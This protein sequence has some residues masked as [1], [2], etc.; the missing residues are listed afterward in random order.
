VTEVNEGDLVRG[1]LRITVPADR[2]FVA[3]E[4]LLPGGLEVVDL[5]LRT[6]SLGPFQSEASREA[7]RL[8][9]RANPAASSLPWMYGT[10]AGG[11]WSPWEHK[12]V[13][14]DRVVYFARVLWKG[15]YTASYV[16]RATTAG[17][18]VRPPAHA[19]EMYNQSLGGRSEGGTFTVVPRR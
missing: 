19:E 5:S 4:D 3:V 1:R 8:G 6:T 12:E 16:A 9:D 15:S 7:E 13:R 18:F 10:W 11:W 14:D 17:T 2:E